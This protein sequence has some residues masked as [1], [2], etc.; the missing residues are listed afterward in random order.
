MKASNGELLH[1]S[2]PIADGSRRRVLIA[3][4]SQ[5]SADFLGI[6]LDLEGCD[7]RV[8][9]GGL[10]ALHMAETFLPDLAFID[11]SMPDLDGHQVASRIRE[12]P[13]G[14]RMLLVATTGW[15]KQEDRQQTSEEGFDR[16]LTKPLDLGELKRLLAVPPYM[17]PRPE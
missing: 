7:V 9:Y 11:I 2:S 10:E 16:Y 6:L 8:V 1:P 13:W 12:Q 17:R 4:D 5:D 14:R 3:D 15:T